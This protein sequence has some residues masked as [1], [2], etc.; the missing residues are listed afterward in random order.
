MINWAYIAGFFDGEGNI[1]KNRFDRSVGINAK[2][3]QAG[4]RGEKVLNEIREFL[5]LEGIY[6]IVKL[7]RRKGG[8]WQECYELLIDRRVDALKFL[9]S[10]YPYLH[11]KK[12][13]AQDH[14][15]FHKIFPPLRYN[16]M[17]M[18][19]GQYTRFAKE[20]EQGI[21]RYRNGLPRRH[22]HA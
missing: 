17:L 11:V 14:L 18:S 15:R 2:I 16:R 5:S 9:S 7:T 10:M 1:R 19:E 4:K 6:S 12:V 20:R 22:R 8:T 21:G 3:T 13:E